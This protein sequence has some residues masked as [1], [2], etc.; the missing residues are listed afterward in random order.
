MPTSIGCGPESKSRIITV[1]Q[2]R[3]LM[4]EIQLKPTEAGYKV[5][6]IVAADRLI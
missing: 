4:R 6:V 5:A 1:D 3:D 2:M